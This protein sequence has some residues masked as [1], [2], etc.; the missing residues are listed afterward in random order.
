MNANRKFT[1]IASII[2]LGIQEDDEI[3]VKINKQ[4][5]NAVSLLISIAGLLWSG[6][7]GFLKLYIA[8]IF[9]LSYSIT[10]FFAILWHRKTK[11]YAWFV[12]IQLIA[13]LV[14]PFCVQWSLGGFI[15]SGAVMV[16]AVLCPF[17]SL[18]FQK[19]ETAFKWLCAYLSLCILSIFQSYVYIPPPTSEKIQLF[20]FGMN[21][22]AVSIMSFFILSYFVKVSRAEF[23]LLQKQSEEI[24]SKEALANSYARFVPAEFLRFLNKTSITELV[25]GDYKNDVMTVFFSDIRNFTTI[26]ER[27]SPKE[28]LGFLN[29][30]FSVAE[31][32][33][34]RNSGLVDKFIGDAIMGVFPQSPIDSLL[35]SI[36]LIKSIK[37][38]N[39]NDAN[40]TRDKLE[41]GIGIHTGRVVF[42]TI[43]SEKRMDTT[44]IGDTV[45][46][47]SR[48]EA[49]TKVYH[50]PILLSEDSYDLI[51]HNFREN[52]R[53]IGVVNVRGREKPVKIYEA[54]GANSPGVIEKKNLSLQLFQ[55]SLALYER[56]QYDRAKRGFIECQK[57][58]PEDPVPVVYIDACEKL[59]KEALANPTYNEENTR[60]SIL[61]VDDNI[62]IIKFI[63]RFLHKNNFI[64][65][66]AL[67]GKNALEVYTRI[68][69]D[70]IITDLYMPG[71][72]GFQVAEKITDI[73]KYKESKPKFIF[74]TSENSP[75][76][77]GRI[78]SLGYQYIEKP[79]DFG[80]L[81]KIL[82]S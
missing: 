65:H 72:D 36:E 13:I 20:F 18:I 68:F 58:C 28:T 44:V 47:A 15:N 67:N 41:I 32:I 14:L 45:N 74:M 37:E 70:T 34:N 38:L 17:G 8:A 76:I 66:H 46:L 25:H 54:F 53:N 60:Q 71:I 80:K 24:Q 77:V 33:I 6:M 1:R 31:P 23:T 12:R 11:N 61:L 29:S 4:L 64:V 42:G 78:K 48:L 52:I 40:Y 27:R 82:T 39:L 10:I 9:P 75:E 26:S 3:S 30:Y 19:P 57:E 69:P 43:G 51:T 50:V 5:L 2:Q 55:E 79:V 62:A 59:K 56:K 73:A 63:E 81:L 21:I 49:L 16:W 22:A 35:A 7:Y